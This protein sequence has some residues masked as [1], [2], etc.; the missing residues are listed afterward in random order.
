MNAF[1]LRK[2]VYSEIFVGVCFL[3]ILQSQDENM[4]FYL[5]SAN[6]WP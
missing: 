6:N 1:D 5:Q 3:Y 2:N 4:Y